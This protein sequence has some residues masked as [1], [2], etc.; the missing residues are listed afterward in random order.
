MKN[1]QNPDLISYKEREEAQGGKVKILFHTRKVLS[2]VLISA[3]YFFSASLD[4]S[5][6]TAQGQEIKICSFPLLRPDL[7]PEALTLKWWG[8]RWL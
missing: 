5:V 4:F 7:V 8:M 3:G 6:D 2:S 1:I